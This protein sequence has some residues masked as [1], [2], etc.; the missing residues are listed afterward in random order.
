MDPQPLPP[1]APSS[2]PQEPKHPKWMIHLTSRTT[3]IWMTVITI[4]LIVETGFLYYKNLQLTRRVDQMTTPAPTPF[5]SP[6]PATAT[7]TDSIVV[8]IQ[9]SNCCSCPTPIPLTQ[10]GKDG[11]VI[12]EQ[13]KNYA[14]QRPGQCKLVDCAPCQP[15]TTPGTSAKTGYTCPSNGWIDCM[16]QPNEGIRYECTP[17]AMNWYKSNCPN[18]KGGAM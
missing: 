10:I 13:G 1:P 4:L 9:L 18:F 8:G 7:N 11:W 6:T 16:P 14:S 12:Y 3:V 17:E 15:L 2:Q 5:P